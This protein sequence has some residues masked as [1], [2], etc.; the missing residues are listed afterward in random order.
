MYVA[1]RQE[2]SCQFSRSG[3]KG[4]VS[5]ARTLFCV[6]YL[7]NKIKNL[8]MGVDVA[9]IFPDDLICLLLQNFR[10]SAHF[11]KIIWRP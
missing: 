2:T 8:K 7:F 5:E 1:M 9:M 11:S 10:F 6:F 4:V 3:E